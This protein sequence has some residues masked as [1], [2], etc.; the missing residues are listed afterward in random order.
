M[1]TIYSLIRSKTETWIKLEKENNQSLISNTL[2]H[3]EE[4]GKLRPP[5]R[6][7]IEIYLWIKF[8]GDN[9][10][11]SEMVKEGLLYDDVVAQEYDNYHTFKGNYVTQFL[12]HFFQDNGLKILHNKLVNAPAGNT[13]DWNSLLDEFLHNFDYSNYLYSLPMGAGKTFLMACFIYLDLYFATLFK[14]DK[15]FAHNFVVFAPQA[16]KTAILPSLR[17][18]KDFTPEWILPKEEADKLKQGITIEILDSLSSKRKDKL[19][20]NNPNLEKVN[21]IKQTKVLE[22]YSLQTLKK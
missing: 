8:A 7:A 14:K 20:G 6:E 16:S 4:T 18:I 15:R 1:N 17:T 11:L 9:K 22:W 5:Q 2:K 12:N 13:I 3:I 21:R 10:R 19:H